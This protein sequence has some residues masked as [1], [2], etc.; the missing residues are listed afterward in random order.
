MSCEDGGAVA[1]IDGETDA[2]Q[3][4]IVSYLYDPR[5]PCYVEAR[6]RIYVLDYSIGGLSVIDCAINA[7]VGTKI[8]GMLPDGMA[9]DTSGE[10]L[11]VVDRGT[12]QLSVISTDTDSL[13]GVVHIPA[14]MSAPVFINPGTGKLY[15]FASR[16]GRKLAVVDTEGDSVLA[17]IGTHESPAAFAISTVSNRI[18]VFDDDTSLVAVVD[19]SGDTVS[20]YILLGEPP[21]CLGYSRTL[22]RVYAIGEHGLL[23]AIDC[24]TNSVVAETHV[25]IP[26]SIPL[27]NP[28]S[29]KL[30]YRTIDDSLGVIDCQSGEMTAH[31]GFGAFPTARLC[32]T[33][34]NKVYVTDGSGTVWF[35][36][37]K[38]DSV[39]G[40]VEIPAC[41]RDMAWCPGRRRVYACCSP[42][43]VAVLRDT[44]TGIAEGRRGSRS[45]GAPTVVRG[46][47]LLTGKQEATMLDIAGRMVMN[48]QPGQNDIRHLAPGVYFLREGPRGQ[49]AEGSSV[50]K[51]VIQR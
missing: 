8:I 46:V 26:L 27:W 36:D 9:A 22:D 40:H 39:V 42:S 32:D 35:V 1:V 3:T 7:L 31:L 25:R 23:S 28:V 38:T 45:V 19:G 11:F 29:N 21:R 50:R 33:L 49:G 15:C 10:K 43:S 17:F 30:Y 51:I 48:L 13:V 5:D 41:P 4:V 14:R 2:V 37:G 20:A 16:E 18:Y 34:A 6:D 24:R 47:F 12:C 44:V